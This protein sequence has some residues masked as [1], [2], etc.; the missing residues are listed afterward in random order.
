MLELLRWKHNHWPNGSLVL[1]ADC[2]CRKFARAWIFTSCLW[3][4]GF[5]ESTWKETLPWKTN[6]LISKFIAKDS[7]F[8]VHSSKILKMHQENEIDWIFVLIS[9]DD[10][11]MEAF[12]N[13]FCVFCWRLYTTQPLLLQSLLEACSNV[14]ID[15]WMTDL[16]TTEAV[17]FFQPLKS[18]L[19]K[20]L[21]QP[22]SGPGFVPLNL[23]T[24]GYKSVLVPP[25]FVLLGVLR[26]FITCHKVAESQMSHFCIPFVAWCR[27]GREV[28]KSRWHQP[29]RSFFCTRCLALSTLRLRSA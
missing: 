9:L 23:T 2:L 21:E 24:C 22:F 5:K 15:L 10:S 3:P 28:L 6:C 17:H 19:I 4:G 16:P 7:I 11:G 18:D 8:M 25:F 14:Q 20:N 12:W 29:G 13:G 26:D 1:V 27:F